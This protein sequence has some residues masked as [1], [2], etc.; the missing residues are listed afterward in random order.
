MGSSLVSTGEIEFGDPSDPDV[1]PREDGLQV[2]SLEVTVDEE[3]NEYTV[4]LLGEGQ[5]FS[6]GANNLASIT[7]PIVSASA[8]DASGC[9]EVVKVAEL[10][11]GITADKINRGL[12]VTAARVYECINPLAI[13]EVDFTKTMCADT[14][15]AVEDALGGVVAW[16]ALNGGY[17]L[18][19]G[20]DSVMSVMDQVREQSNGNG[21]SQ[22]ETLTSFALSLL[23]GNCVPSTVDGCECCCTASAESEDGMLVSASRVLATQLSTPLTPALVFYPEVRL[24]ANAEF[25][26]GFDRFSKSECEEVYIVSQTESQM[27]AF[28]APEGQSVFSGVLNGGISKVG[29]AATLAAAKKRAN[30]AN[31]PGSLQFDID[32][33]SENNNRECV[34]WNSDDST[35]SSEGCV[36]TQQVESIVT[37]EC[38]QLAESYALLITVNSSFATFVTAGAAIVVVASAI[39]FFCCFVIAA[40]NK[41]VTG[42]VIKHVAVA[43]MLLHLMFIINT[44]LTKTVDATGQFV[45]GLLLHYCILA[46]AFALTAALYFLYSRFKTPDTGAATDVMSKFVQWAIWIVPLA[47]VLCSILWGLEV[48]D[49]TDAVYGDMSGNDK[50][51]LI[52]STGLFYAGFLVEF[53]LAGIASL[54]LACSTFVGERRSDAYD[55]EAQMKG[56]SKD[57]AELST[58]EIRSTAAILLWCWVGPVLALV[59][60]STGVTSIEYVVALAMVIQGISLLVYCFVMADPGDEPDVIDE[61][62]NEAAP[63]VGDGPDSSQ[64]MVLNTMTSFNSMHGP[65]RSAAW[66]AFDAQESTGAASPYSGGAPPA[67]EDSGFSPALVDTA[68]FDDLIFSLKTNPVSDYGVGGMGGGGAAPP[69]IVELSTYGGGGGSTNDNRLSIADTHL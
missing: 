12:Q 57:T 25:L 8:V 55:A 1:E 40:L 58:T 48:Y 45:L 36:E 6:L 3:S 56:A 64:P 63:K 41:S 19:G 4:E 20:L 52:P 49:T 54:V 24:P 23:A 59:T 46:Y 61:V 33:G 65:S 68:E 66:T 39:L 69:G 37:C 21:N 35:W 44:M 26:A 32:V 38:E 11:H 50:I 15:K 18:I 67:A 31:P 53:V 7:I 10:C 30:S 42:A 62:S 34:A 14:I 5:A 9:T 2:Y 51:S 29:F 47:A 17:A 27:G 43:S 16:A 60:V 28:K 13:G 22:G